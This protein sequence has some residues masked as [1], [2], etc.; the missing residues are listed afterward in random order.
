VTA[1]LAAV[2]VHWQDLEDTRGCVESLAGEGD[3]DI[4]VVDN[5]SREPVG[6]TLGPRVACLRSSE[7]R[8][9]A[10][11]ANL[12]IRAALEG[13]ADTVLLLNNDVRLR[14]GACAAAVTRLAV[15]PRIAAVGPK[16]LSREDPS[17]LWLAWGEVTYRQSLVALRGAGEPDGPQFA[18]QRDVQWI[19]GCAMWLRREALEAI[20]LLDEAFF[21]YHEE[22][23]WCTRARE[24]GWRVVYCPAAVVT[25][26]GRGAAGGTAAVRIRKYFAAR[27]T[28]LFARKH[29][30][31]AQRLKLACFLAASLPLQ[32]ARHWPA[33][34][35]HEVWL[36]MRGIRD[37]LAGRR[38]PFEALGLR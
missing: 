6:T 12:G 30:T 16:V 8:G 19:A 11:G 7:N 22:V 27:N 28:I 3:V 29:A 37:A 13:G 17:R 4:L 36:K 5:G 23:D 10:G 34:S 32:L 18:Q 20:G 25:H 2:I 33:G 38:P 9:Y 21:A 15:D 1:R 14:R 35:T 24:T 31:P 26:T